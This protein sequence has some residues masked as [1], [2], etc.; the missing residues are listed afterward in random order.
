MNPLVEFAILNGYVPAAVLLVFAI[1]CVLVYR[2]T[3]P[4][5]VPQFDGTMMMDFDLGDESQGAQNLLQVLKTPLKINYLKIMTVP[6]GVTKERA[7]HAWVDGEY[8][9]SIGRGE[10]EIAIA[11][12]ELATH[13]I[14]MPPVGSWKRAQKMIDRNHA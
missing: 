4:R 11:I 10:E 8:N 14:A 1:C 12:S 3:R 7:L 6:K 9:R 2:A 13:G 5:S